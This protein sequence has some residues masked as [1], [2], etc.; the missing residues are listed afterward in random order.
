VDEAEKIIL[1]THPYK[2]VDEIY[3]LTDSLEP[4]RSNVL[5][6][7]IG[8]RVHLTA[9]PNLWRVWFPRARWKKMRYRFVLD[10]KKLRTDFRYYM[11]PVY[12]YS[13]E[14]EPPEIVLK[15]YEMIVEKYIPE[16]NPI[17]PAG[18]FYRGRDLAI[19]C[20][21]LVFDDIENLDE[22]LI[23]YEE[24]GSMYKTIKELEEELEKLVKEVKEVKEEKKLP[25]APEV[26][27]VEIKADGKVSEF[28]YEVPKP[29]KEIPEVY[30]IPKESDPSID[31]S[32]WYLRIQ[33]LDGQPKHDMVVKELEKLKGVLPEE[34]IRWIEA[35]FE[36]PME[37]RKPIPLCKETDK[38]LFDLEKELK[39]MILD[40]F[41]D[42]PENEVEDYVQDAIFKAIM[43][44]KGFGDRRK[45]ELSAKGQI[46]SLLR[47]IG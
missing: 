5:R 24:N 37:E 41:P 31:K 27:K 7:G 16:A 18:D 39:N 15:Y 3:H 11:V 25:R 1:K 40:K 44:A 42:A 12:Y 2:P 46:R 22:Y 20:E 26:G 43:S 36:K 29:V 14:E 6:R 8:G 23:R 32:L 19:E 34:T 10:F 45:L 13:P 4:V 17:F 28:E 35:Q 9:N 33:A 30:G 47:M 38:F 21:W